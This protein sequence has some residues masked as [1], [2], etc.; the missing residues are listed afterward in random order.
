[1]LRTVLFW[2]HLSAGVVAGTIVLVMSVTGV[3]LTYERQITHWADLRQLQADHAPASCCLTVDSIL[4]LASDAKPGTAPTSVTL[5]A[6]HSEPAQISFARAGVLFVGQ[7]SGAVL[8]AGSTTTREFFGAVEDWHR[9][10]AAEG[11]SRRTFKNITGVANLL[12]LLLVL[13]GMVLWLPRS[14]SWLKVRAV[15][16]FRSGLS[17]K[18]RD[19]NWHNVLGIWSALPLIAIVAS[20][21]VIGYPWAGDLVYRAVG[22]TPPPRTPPGPPPNASATNASASVTDRSRTTPPASQIAQLVA[23]KVSYAEMVTTASTLMP[24]WK[25][26]TLQIPN[27]DA[28]T[29]TVTLDRGTGGQPQLRANV[30]LSAATGAIAK[31]QPF[32]SLSTGRQARSVLRFAHTGEVLGIF[33]QT[34]AGLVSLAALVLVVTGISLAIRRAFRALA[35]RASKPSESV[36]RVPT[37]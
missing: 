2:L 26:L 8:G 15:L 25:A 22:E 27:P 36:A 16:W 10:L 35:R 24:E 20:G 32:D 21:T 14:W 11:P 33:G 28:K 19:F 13:T 37:T 6:D 18:A 12:F 31:Y 3:L 7:A 34:L 29:V 30:Q 1:M 23:T 9:W 5:S 4:W 17:G